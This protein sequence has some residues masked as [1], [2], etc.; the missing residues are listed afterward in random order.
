MWPFPFASGVSAALCLLAGLILA[1]LGS[2]LALCKPN[3]D[4][5]VRLPRSLRMTLSALLVVGAAVAWLLGARGTPA[6]L[7]ALFILLGMFAGFVG[8]L[9]MARLIPVPGRLICGMATF[10]AGHL[11]YSAAFA[12]LVVQLGLRWVPVHL[13]FTVSLL[14]FNGW[15]WWNHIRKPGGSRA[16]NLGSLLYAIV[17]TVMTALALSLAV[18][19]RHLVGL[20]CGALLFLASD[21]MLGNWQVRGHVWSSVNDAIW[22][23]YVLGQLLIVYSIAGALNILR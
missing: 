16:V 23:T 19:N 10:G 5:T 9:I 20:G 18:Q 6:G 15:V 4:R 8:D 1:L 3:V 11:W 22:T 12:L 7:Y 14:L 17:I 21:L 2:G 13:L